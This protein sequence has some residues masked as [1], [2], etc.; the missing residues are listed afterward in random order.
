MDDSNFQQRVDSTKNEEGEQADDV[1]T[2]KAFRD[3]WALGIHSYLS[4]LCERLYLCRELLTAS[5]FADLFENLPEKPPHFF[6]KLER[7]L[8]CSH[9]FP[10]LYVNHF[11]ARDRRHPS[12]PPAVNQV[13]RPLAQFDR[14][15]PVVGSRNAAPLHICRVG[16]SHVKAGFR[17]ENCGKP[18]TNSAQ[19]LMPKGI[20]LIAFYNMSFEWISFSHYYDA[21]MFPLTTSLFD[22]ITNRFYRQRMLRNQNNI[23]SAGHTT[24]KCNPTGI[25]SH[26]LDNV[27]HVM[28]FRRRMKPVNGFGHDSISR[29]KPDGRVCPAE[30]VIDCLGHADNRQVELRKCRIGDT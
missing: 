19:L 26:D 11:I 6:E 15:I 24:S 28:G 1:V 27:D 30:I 20:S 14:N 17:F 13:H 12:K 25:S 2:I 3:T 4:Y 10:E 29:S 8:S 22:Q 23:R 16:D 7:D 9:H 18:I 5:G 21:E